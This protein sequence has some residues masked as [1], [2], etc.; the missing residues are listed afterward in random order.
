M[1][2]PSPAPLYSMTGFGRAERRIDGLPLIVE[3]KGVN[4]RY[5]DIKIRL[6]SF[7]NDSEHLL[8]QH[9]QKV[10]SR[11]R[12]EVNI[13]F[14]DN[15]EMLA[16]PR[17][18]LDL[19]KHYQNLYEQLQEQLAYDE[20]SPLSAEKMFHL[21][22]VLL[23]TLAP[24]DSDA[25]REQL[26]ETLEA[27][28][29]PFLEM[30]EREGAN[31]RSDMQQRL[32]NIEEELQKIAAR[33]PQ[34]PAEQFQKLQQ[35]LQE[36]PLSQPVDPQRLHQEIAVWADKSDISEEITR[37][38]SHIEQFL[39]LLDAGG[40]IGRRLDFLCQEMHREATTMGVKA[41]DSSIIHWLLPIK[42]EIEKIREQVQNIE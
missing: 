19:V 17:L 21:P 3:L 7:L 35:R 27:A 36:L 33:A 23:T 12:T 1:K 5:N 11:G 6:P 38:R 32:H 31:L 28:L 14:G 37:L 13:R 2:S 41:Q 9:L 10:I 18:N 22:G 16:Q 24:E 29:A 20:S 25:L 30:R 39:K 42:A 8:R 4:H 15:A 40:V 34:L 26:I